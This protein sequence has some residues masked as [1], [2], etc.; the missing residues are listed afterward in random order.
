MKV[1]FSRDASRDARALFL[2]WGLLQVIG[3]AA[4]PQ[5]DRSE[6]PR[7]LVTCRD[8][9]HPDSDV[10]S[11]MMNPRIRISIKNGWAERFVQQCKLYIDIGPGRI[12]HAGMEIGDGLA[13]QPERVYTLVGNTDPDA[14]SGFS[15]T[16]A[17]QIELKPLVLGPGMET[18]WVIE[19]SRLK[20]FI[21]NTWYLSAGYPFE[22]ERVLDR[23]G[24]GREDLAAQKLSDLR[25]C[26]EVYVIPDTGAHRDVYRSNE[27]RIK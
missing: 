21:H 14:D 16:R 5:H 18:S 24:L 26:V 17:S 22:W 4:A 15:L 11:D 12:A 27:L 20:W 10:L 13:L 6:Q 23:R 8:A 1:V 9:A 25:L 7:L 2:C 3:C 19:L